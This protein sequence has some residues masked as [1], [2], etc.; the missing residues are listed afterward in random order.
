MSITGAPID[1]DAEHMPIIVH[2]R[3]NET[4]HGGWNEWSAGCICGWY[5][6]TT[7]T[8]YIPSRNSAESLYK[9]HLPSFSEQSEQE[10][11]TAEEALERWASSF[12]EDC[13]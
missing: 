11:E 1:P 2:V 10:I 6:S 9:A 8:R 4:E 12:M 7:S 3:F 5:R 13:V